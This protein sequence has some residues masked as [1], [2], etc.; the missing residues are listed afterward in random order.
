MKHRLA[1]L[2][3]TR[4]L[5]GVTSVDDE[6]AMVTIEN[7]PPRLGGR[8]WLKLCQLSARYLEQYGTNVTTIKYKPPPDAGQQSHSVAL[9]WDDLVLQDEESGVNNAL[10]F[11]HLYQL[12]TERQKLALCGEDVTTS[13]AQ[14]LS[15]AFHLKHA[16]WGREAASEDAELLTSPLMATLAAVQRAP[17]RGWPTVRQKNSI[18]IS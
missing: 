17:F 16:R 15:R 3:H 10:G 12:L 5:N 4:K 6:S 8:P 9:V 14:L 11:L 18:Y 1:V 13:L 2:R 7:E